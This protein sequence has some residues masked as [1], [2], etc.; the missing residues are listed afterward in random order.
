[1]D[2]TYAER[3]WLLDTEMKLQFLFIWRVHRYSDL[4]LIL[5]SRCT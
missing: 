2:E 5:Q 4:G 3:G 1:V